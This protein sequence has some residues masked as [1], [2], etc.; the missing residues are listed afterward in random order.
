[1]DADDDDLDA[2]LME[3]DAARLAPA[4]AAV[5]ARQRAVAT[6]RRAEE[7]V[8]RC[9]LCMGSA[10]FSAASVVHV[11]THVCVILPPWPRPR[12]DPEH[13]LL[14]PRE[15]VASMIAAD[16][17]TYKECND[18]KAQLHAHF[19]ASGRDVVF[20]ETVRRVDGATAHTCVEAVPVDADV[21][22]D[23]P[24]Y[25]H[26][27]LMEAGEEWAQ[28]RKIIDLAGRG[29]RRAVPPNFPYFAVGWRGGG[30]AQVIEDEHAWSATFGLDVLAGMLGLPPGAFGRRGAQRPTTAEDHAATA[31]MRHALAG[32]SASAPSPP[33]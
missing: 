29:L 3:D 10:A 8:A 33:A 24:I 21:G 20:L 30:Y 1:L 2:R 17:D 19:A 32:P 28:H 27:A 7:A 6:Q 15:H 5:R 11:G 22:A 13:V 26:K 18:L 25:F 16:E 12:L 31:A 14:V 23:A 9:S 4:E